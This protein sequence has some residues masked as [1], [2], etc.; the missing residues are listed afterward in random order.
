MERS[1]ASP[2]PSISVVVPVLNDADCLDRLCRRLKSLPHIREVVVA[3]GGSTDSLQK[4]VD[5]HDL[6][7][8]SSPMGRGIQMNRG[9]AIVKGGILWFLHADTLPEAGSTDEIIR[10]L[11]KE[12]T[13]GG[14]FRFSLSE[15]RRYGAM[16]EFFI[17]LRS[18]YLSMP[19]GDQGYFVRRRDF[20]EVGG[21]PEIPIMEDVEFL[22]RIKT[23]GRFQTLDLRIGISPRRW[24]R[25]GVV[26]RTILN[27]T[28]MI[29]HKLGASP[30]SL[31][32]SYPAKPVE[33]EW[34]AD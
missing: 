12:G 32:R 11:E 7:L 24:D 4:V 19:Y 30:E 17:G 16:F 5:I 18:K 20:E 8:V 6:V 3:D 15:P 31:A 28:L 33:S 10:R 22:R 27:W 1:D 13:V 26:K 14:A 25:E 9:A 23:R 29:R 21:F 2:D 34:K